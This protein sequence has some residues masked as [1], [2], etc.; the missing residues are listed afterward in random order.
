MNGWPF[1]LFKPLGVDQVVPAEQQPELAQVH[2]GNQHV[3]EPP[4]D[5]AQVAPAADSDS[6]HGT[7]ETCDALAAKLKR[8]G[9]DG[10]EGAAPAEDQH[11][12]FFRPG[13]E[14]IAGR[15]A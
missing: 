14:H 8:G 11:V 5:L 4:A 3:L 12:A 10:A 6:A 2:L 7:A 13:P 1:T 15:S 9:L